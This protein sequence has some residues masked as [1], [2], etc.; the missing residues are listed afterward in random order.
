MTTESNI[1]ADILIVDDT[2][3]SLRLLATMLENQGYRTRPVP[4]GRLALQAVDSVPPDL[5]LLDVNMPEMNGFEV[6]KRLK[7][8]SQTKHIPVIFISALNDTSDKANAFRVGGVDYITKPYQFEEVEARIR[9]HIELKRV[10]L[11][12]SDQN[13]VLRENLQLREDIERIIHHDLKTPLNSIFVSPDIIRRDGGLNERQNRCLDDI[14]EAGRRMLTMI[15]ESLDLYKME[16]GTY[17]FQ[18]NPID[19]LDEIHRVI[20]ENLDFE[21]SRGIRVETL[22]DGLPV[23]NQDVCTVSGEKLLIYSILSNIIKNSLEA[24][25]K[26]Q[27]VNISI[28]DRELDRQVILRI[29]NQGAVPDEIRDR[30]FDKYVTSGKKSGTGLGTYS[31][32]LMAE[33][34]GATITMDTSEETGTTITVCFTQPES[35]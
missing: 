2:I 33:A 21:Q 19:L 10:R 27:T 29:N 26:E 35:C 15:N 22:V 12:L 23:T 5:I 28:E 17:E 24:S 11:E 30:F 18:P 32:K 13:Y 34:Q 9:T 1:K 25:P 16:T 20:R 14:Q 8:K 4:N 31:A 7:A 6:C 3:E